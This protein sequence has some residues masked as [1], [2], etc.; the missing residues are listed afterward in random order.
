MYS[1]WCF[2]LNRPDGNLDVDLDH[3]AQHGRLKYAIWQLECGEG[4]TLHYQGYLELPRNQ[5]LSYVRKIIPGAHF[6][7][8]FG[9]REQ[10][11]DYARKDDTRIEGPYEVGVWE[12]SQQGKRNDIL[13][14]KEAI[15]S[16]SS[17]LELFER[18]PREFLS[19]QRGISAARGLYETKRS[20]ITE[21]IVLLG[22]PGTGK[23]TY[24]RDHA[25]SLYVKQ[26]SKWWDRYD[27]EEDVLLDDFYGWLPFH[28]LLR[29]ADCLPHMVEAKGAQVQFLAKRLWITSNK[30]IVEWYKGEHFVWQALFRRVTKLMVFKRIGE[31]HTYSSYDDFAADFSSHSMKTRPVYT[32]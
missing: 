19:Y 16:G 14:L 22:D 26:A 1:H 8:R 32:E 4:G 5:R 23:S 29:L 25:E 2:T 13:A 30:P 31:I 11:R 18:F 10:A 9:T 17:N 3:C 15:K 27:G 21:L 7:P 20:W 6:E 12:D 24:V 28:E